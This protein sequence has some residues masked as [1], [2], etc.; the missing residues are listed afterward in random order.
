M[1]LNIDALRMVEFPQHGDAQN[2]LAVFQSL[3]DVPFPIVRVFTVRSGTGVVRGQHAHKKCN[4]LLICLSGR[5][6]VTCFDGVAKVTRLL[7][8]WNQGLLVP[9]GIW[10]EEKYLDPESLMMVL[11]DQPY[12]ADDYIRDHQAYLAFRKA[13]GIL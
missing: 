8:R 12:E 2:G 11:C 3:D 1:S 9:A 7:E 4:Q 10:C 13:G 5:C 6:E